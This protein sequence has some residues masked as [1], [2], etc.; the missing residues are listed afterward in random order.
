M[1]IV[2]T[3]ELYKEICNKNNINKKYRT[4]KK[5]LEEIH[6]ENFQ[7]LSFKSFILRMIGYDIVAT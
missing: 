4:Y 6:K 1:K 7:D 2:F 3:E 5:T